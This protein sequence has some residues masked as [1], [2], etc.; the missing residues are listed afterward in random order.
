MAGKIQPMDLFVSGWNMLE[1]ST[2]DCLRC[3]KMR[4]SPNL[5]IGL[6]RPGALCSL[7][8]VFYPTTGSGGKELRDTGINIQTILLVKRTTAR[9]VQQSLGVAGQNF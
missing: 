3:K 6:G 2:L 4:I 1:P 9:R 5:Q 7:A 8:A